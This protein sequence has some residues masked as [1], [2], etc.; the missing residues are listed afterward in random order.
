MQEGGMLLHVL[1]HLWICSFVF[2]KLCGAADIP[3]TVIQD[4]KRTL[5]S[6]PEFNELDCEYQW[7]NETGHVVANVMEHAAVVEWNTNR[8]LATYECSKQIIYSRNC[9]PEVDKQV[10][11]CTYNCSR[12]SAAPNEAIAHRIIPVAISVGLLLLLLLLVLLV[13]LCYTFRDRITRCLNYTP[14][15][16][17]DPMIV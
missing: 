3:C 8:T 4:G 6:V 16:K 1:V 12:N 14:V 11:T 5:Y 2:L 13:L 15:N 9:Y 17:Q 10:A 7:L